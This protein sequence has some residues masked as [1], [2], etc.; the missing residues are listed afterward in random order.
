[1]Q[2]SGTSNVTAPNGLRES[3]IVPGAVSNGSGGFVAN[4]KQVTPQQ[5]WRGIATANN[6]GI[7]E[8][9][10]YD[11]SNIRLRNV[12][13][14]YSISRKYLANTPIKNAKFGVSCNNVWLI[15]SHMNGIDPESVYAT[16]GNATGFEN[17]GLPTMRTFLI[18]LALGF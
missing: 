1:M 14:S 2:A 17:A 15:K 16:S 7:S 11:A 5:Y 13:L 8:A 12:Q 3:F 6:L 4:T 18:N 10:I 9:N